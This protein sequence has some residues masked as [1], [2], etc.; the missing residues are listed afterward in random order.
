MAK[1]RREADVTARIERKN[2][3]LLSRVKGIAILMNPAG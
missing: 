1:A 3:E 2:N